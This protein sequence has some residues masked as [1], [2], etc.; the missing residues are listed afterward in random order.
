VAIDADTALYYDGDEV[1]GI[2]GRLTRDGGH[3]WTTFP[4]RP[5]TTVQVSRSRRP[6]PL[7]AWVI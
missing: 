1:A 6:G 3:T 5:L 2:V 7:L 4:F